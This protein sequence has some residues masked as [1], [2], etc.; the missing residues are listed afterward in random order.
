M[1]KHYITQVV[2]EPGAV[3]A[4]LWSVEIRT[5]FFGIRM[6]RIFLAGWSGVIAFY[7]DPCPG[8]SMPAPDPGRRLTLA[9]EWVNRDR[10]TKLLAPQ[11]VSFLFR[12]QLPGDALDR[13]DRFR[14]GER[15]YA[16]LEGQFMRWSL[17]GNPLEGQ[18]EVEAIVAA[19]AD[20]GRVIWADVRSE[21]HELSRDVWGVSVLSVLRPPGIVTLE[22][23]LPTDESA[24]Q[25]LKRALAHLNEAQRALD[26]NQ[27]DRVAQ[28]VYRAL[29]EL[30]GCA[31]Q[32]QTSRGEFITRRLLDERKALASICD[33]ERH[34]ERPS[35]PTGD[36]DRTLAQHIL[37]AAKS[38]VA[39]FANHPKR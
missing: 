6:E 28:I 7:R 4:L 14:G 24:S 16:R 29:D 20:P 8:H 30:K 17:D 11:E 1:G 34:G 15:L 33:P 31:D 21:S 18:D 37:A 35:G 10:T 27:T 2:P 36:V 9:A 26:H 22:I 23:R 19:A 12:T 32:V 13:I 39:V 25:P 5:D 38:L 3:D